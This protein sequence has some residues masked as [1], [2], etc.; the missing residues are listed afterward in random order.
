MSSTSFATRTEIKSRFQHMKRQKHIFVWIACGLLLVAAIVA[1]IVLVVRR[2]R[3][4]HAALRELQEWNLADTVFRSNSAAQ[5]LVDYFDHPW[6]SANDQ[7]LAYYLLG[8][9]HADMGEAPQAIEAYQTAIERADTTDSDCDF[10]ILRN[11]YGQ[12]AEVYGRQGLITHEL[13]ACIQY[14]RFSS[15]INDIY[16]YARNKLYVSEIFYA[17]NDTASAWYHIYEAKKIF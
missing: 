11:I 4:M 7:M 8:R 5:V 15:K 1:G 16:E 9:T 2:D 10:R 14:G 3:A 12:M 17:V 13:D 6:H